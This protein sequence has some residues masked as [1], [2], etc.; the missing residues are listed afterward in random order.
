MPNS[1]VSKADTLETAGYAYSFDREL[2]LNRKTKKVFSIDYIEDHSEEQ[3]LNRIREKNPGPGWR[4]Y[5]N[6]EPS[7][8][9]RHQLE[10]VLG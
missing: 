7:P 5:F 9:V 2:Y 10:L 8:A 4:F 3:L 6:G 1:T